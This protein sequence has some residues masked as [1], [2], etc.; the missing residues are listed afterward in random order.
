MTSTLTQPRRKDT[1]LP[2]N[3]GYFSSRQMKE[4]LSV[5]IGGLDRP[6]YRLDDPQFQ[7]MRGSIPHLDGA[8]ISFPNDEK[9]R[10]EVTPAYRKMPEQVVVHTSQGVVP[11][12][13][14]SDLE[15]RIESYDGD[16]QR[17]QDELAYQNCVRRV[18]DRTTE[19]MD[20]RDE[21]SRELIPERDYRNGSRIEINSITPPGRVQAVTAATVNYENADGS[22]KGV[23]YFS[24]RAGVGL[25]EGSYD[26]QAAKRIKKVMSAPAFQKETANLARSW[27]GMLVADA[28]L[29]NHYD[30]LE[31]K[32][33]KRH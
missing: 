5:H 31:R 28:E 24:G 32:Y 29:N 22:R 25:T 12:R 3:G 1:G 19:Y 6:T 9:A 15:Y 20:K 7:R 16:A 27:Q 14:M 23:A 13:Y 21:L 4:D 30:Y 17:L 18:W 11:E 26:S 33:G 2:G 8:V 10:L